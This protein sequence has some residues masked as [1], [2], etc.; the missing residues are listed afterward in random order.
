MIPFLRP[1]F[2][3]GPY[4]GILGGL[5]FRVRIEGSFRARPTPSE[6]KPNGKSPP[7]D[8]NGAAQKVASPYVVL[9]PEPVRP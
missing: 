9:A 7:K 2:L 3:Y 4:M 1:F 8:A 6:E 5:C